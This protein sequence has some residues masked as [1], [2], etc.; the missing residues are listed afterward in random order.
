MERKEYLEKCQMNAVY[1]QS[2]KAIHNGGVYYPQSLEI[3]FDSSGYTQNSA[4]M[5]D[6]KANCLVH[7]KLSEV[8]CND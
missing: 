7:C 3:Y 4:I 2:V 1:P 8:E 5:K 6:A